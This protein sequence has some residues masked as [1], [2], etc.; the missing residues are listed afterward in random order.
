M[1]YDDGPEV[2]ASPSGEGLEV[3]D[4]YA[5]YGLESV[6]HMNGDKDGSA[7]EVAQKE[8][9]ESNNQTRLIGLEMNQTDNYAGSFHP[10]RQQKRR[11]SRRMWWIIG[12][13]VLL[14][15]IIIAVLG[16]VLGSRV[17]SGSSSG[18]DPSSPPAGSPTTI[19]PNTG[20][21]SIA[22]SDPNNV[23]HYRVYY[24]DEGLAIRESAWNNSQ[25]VG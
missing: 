2:V 12:A 7:L 6:R 11:R 10:P 15:V 18:S 20:L 19:T 16:G 8:S 25:Q 24:Q 5:G 3:A 13:I 1:S 9:I 21:A 4:L 14:L 23:V 17:H 22:W